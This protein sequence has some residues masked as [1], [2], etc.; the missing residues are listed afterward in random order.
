MRY[1][2]HLALA[3]VLVVPAAAG[4]ADSLKLRYLGSISTDEKDGA[5]K[6]PEGVACNDQGDV[7]VADTG[8]SRLLR[9]TFQ[10]KNLKG[11][12]VL[13]VDQIGAPVRVQY[14]PK[15]DVF[16][17]DG[18]LHKVGRLNSDGS[19]A[20]FVEP[21]GVTGPAKYVI[22]SF[23]VDSANNLFL[24]DILGERVLKVDSTGKVLS[25]IA[26]PKEYGLIS[27]LAITIAG[28]VILLDAVKSVL[29]V[30]RK[31]AAFA[32]L[33]KDLH[34]FMNFANYITAS[35]RSGDIYLV[36]QDGGAIITIGPDGSFLGRQLALGWRTGQLY[37]PAQV[38][39]T[40]NGEVFIADRGNSRVQ[41]F[42]NAK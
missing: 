27:D 5:V 18:K 1:L 30:S 16:V 13:K 23:K 36:D 38:C 25:Q 35:S 4:A 19:F 3:L 26:F 2:V 7:I 14:G 24:L 31:D 6:T 41:I 42:E 22:R 33:T 34:D 15:G 40:K 12:A 20:G 21:V 11:G 28:D 37:Y 9:Y 10:E 17:L 32:P 39:F 8:N 29:Y